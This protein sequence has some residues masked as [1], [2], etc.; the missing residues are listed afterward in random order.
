MPTEPRPQASSSG[1]AAR[2]TTKVPPWHG[3]VAWD[4]LLNNLTTGLFLTAALGELTVPDVFGPLARV[5]YPMAL[6]LLIADLVCLVLDLGDPWRFH[7]MLRVFKPSSPMSLG[8]WSLNLYLMPLILIVVLELIPVPG[9]AYSWIHF[10]A[11]ICGLP[12]AVTTAVY[13]G[14]LFSTSSQ[15]VWREA[16][17][18]GGYLTN[19]ALVLG[20]AT[21]LG[22]SLLMQQERAIPILR[23][24]LAALLVLN[25]IV[26]GLLFRNILPALA[27]IDSSGKLR[28]RAALTVRAGLL[29]PLVLV[30]LGGTPLLALAVLLVLV[31]GLGFRFGIVHWPQ[32]NGKGGCR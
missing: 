23:S 21:L 13:K 25:L 3:L 18:L 30:L 2:P 27:L 24:A 10:L 26:L 11:V 20:C 12:L 6:F 17:W 22:V 14:V 31:G 9:S 7:H 29:V 5:A 15:P 1:Y 19:S 4:I 8:T 28:R 16:R 32:G